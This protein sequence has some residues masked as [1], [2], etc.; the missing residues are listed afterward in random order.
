MN[1]QDKI[2]AAEAR[3]K[4]LQLLIDAWKKQLTKS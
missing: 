1:L 3:Q 4:E 2:K